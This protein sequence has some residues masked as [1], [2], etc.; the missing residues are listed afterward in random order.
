MPQG[1]YPVLKE[2][3]GKNEKGNWNYQLH[4][5]LTEDVGRQD[6]K[7]IINE[8]TAFMEMSDTKE[9]FKRLYNRRYNHAT[10]T[11]V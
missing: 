9:E 5:N 10:R 3:T 7:R 6:L 1:V 8:V 11:T 2:K 4:R